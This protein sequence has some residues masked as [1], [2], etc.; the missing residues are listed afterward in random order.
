MPT[1]SPS[2]YWTVSREGRAHPGAASVTARTKTFAVAGLLWAAACAGPTAPPRDVLGELVI[3]G[4]PPL[5]GPLVT[6]LEA[7]QNTRS[8]VFL[9]WLGEGILISTRF[10]NTAQLHRV[11][12]PLGMRHQVTF[13]EEPVAAAA[14]SPDPDAEGFLYVKD[15]GGSEFFQFFWLDLVTGES[16]LLTDGRSRYSDIAWAASGRRFAYTS[17][18]R[19]GVD[20]DIHVRE[21]GAGVEGGVSVALEGRGVGWTAVDWSPDETRM[22]VRQFVSIDESYLHEVDLT[23]GTSRRLLQRI[24]RA[25]IVEARY[26]SGGERVLFTSDLGGEFVGL[27][28]LDLA[29]GRVEALTADI[30]WN[31]EE[32]TVSR[33]REWLAFTVNEGGMGR[34][35]VF[36][37]PDLEPVS[38]PALPEGIVHALGFSAAGDALGFV[39]NHAAAP[40]DVYSVDLATGSLTRWTQSELGGLDAGDLVAPELVDYPSFDGRRIPAF[41]YRPRR[42][43]PHP[44]LVSIHGGPEAQF[45]PAFSYST[46]FFVNE[47]GLAVV[48]PNVRGSAGYGRTWLSLD[49]GILREDSVRDIGALLDWIDARPDLDGE[50]VAVSG[51]S[52]GGYMVLAS[53]V[54]F[55]DRLKAG[56]ERVG[57]SNFVTFLTNTQGY[58]RDLRRAEYGDERDPEMR[59]FLERISPL[60]HV[61]RMTRPMLISQGLN[62][63]RVPAGESA[64]IVAALR[65]RNVP[66]WYV[67]ARDEG[68]GFRKKL[69]RDYQLAATALFLTRYLLD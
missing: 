19:N 13:F 9:G 10:G 47:L 40:A 3:E 60:N 69:N 58:R 52:Y 20:W 37:L 30:R 5:P 48:A 51:G 62:D 61:D 43:G 28:R 16:T 24:G 45:R 2:A 1:R 57:I 8:A 36:A 11:D 23:S 65:A 21:M 26:E 56:V 29:T 25:S 63:P 46:Q 66:V 68:H 7:Y 15:V 4:V 12:E 35:R 55:G 39:V 59:A 54:H 18:E 27:H 44:V 41:V 31:V 34:P 38:L 17:T 32:F 50:R 64:Q 14:V 33:N 6:R 53:M 49:N 42:P 67:L 22:L